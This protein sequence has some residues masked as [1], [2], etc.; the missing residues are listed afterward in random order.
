MKKAMLVMVVC[1]TMFS[2]HAE[3]YLNLTKQVQEQFGKSV[4]NKVIGIHGAKDGSTNILECDTKIYTGNPEYFRVTNNS[5]FPFIRCSQI[6]S[7]ESYSA[8]K[9]RG[10]V[11]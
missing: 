1:I 3:N 10:H 4:C 5:Q 2:A 7:W 9:C 6:G 11:M 8:K